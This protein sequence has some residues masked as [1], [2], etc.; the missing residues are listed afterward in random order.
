MRRPLRL[1]NLAHVLDHLDF[2]RFDRAFVADKPFQFSNKGFGRRGDLGDHALNRLT[3]DRDDF[4][5]LL[6]RIGNKDRVFD[7]ILKR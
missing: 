5:L 6:I 4:T 7:H 1:D 2:D 3:V